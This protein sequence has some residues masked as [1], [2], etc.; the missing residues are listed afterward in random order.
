MKKAPFI[1]SEGLR[2]H[3]ELCGCEHH[4]TCFSL[5]ECVQGEVIKQ[6]AKW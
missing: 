6:E 2:S 1:S 3:I 5:K 4:K